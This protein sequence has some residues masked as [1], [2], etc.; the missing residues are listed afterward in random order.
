VFTPNL[1]GVIEAQ[2][3]PIATEGRRTLSRLVPKRSTFA[4][5]R[6]ATCSRTFAALVTSAHPASSRLISTRWLYMWLDRRPTAAVD[7]QDDD[8]P[9]WGR[10]RVS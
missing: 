6:V 2:S 10:S 7:A 5:L 4:N 8:R 9:D 3:S 1:K